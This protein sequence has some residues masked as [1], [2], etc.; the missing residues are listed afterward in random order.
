MIGVFYRRIERNEAVETNDQRLDVLI[1]VNMTKP[2][3][4]HLSGG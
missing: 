2:D 1:F 4:H 3:C